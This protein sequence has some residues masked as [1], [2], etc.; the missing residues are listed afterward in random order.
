MG[1][2]SG[3]GIEREI[4]VWFMEKEYKGRYGL[5]RFLWRNRKGQWVLPENE[6]ILQL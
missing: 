6:E 5:I 1:L 2:V 4:W 3:E